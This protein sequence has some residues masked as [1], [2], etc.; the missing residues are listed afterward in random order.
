MSSVRGGLL[1]ECRTLREAEVE[2][3]DGQR[4]TEAQLHESRQEARRLREQRQRLRE[5]HACDVESERQLSAR[6]QEEVAEMETL[7]CRLSRSEQVAADH[8]EEELVLPDIR[9]QGSAA[10]PPGRPPR[11]RG[12]QTVSSIMRDLRIKDG[13]ISDLRRQLRAAS[14]PPPDSEGPRACARGIG[15]CPEVW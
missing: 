14:A 11:R 5:Q 3:A 1:D 10:W 6:L 2:A 12:S 7:R 15:S 8:Q 13:V 9:G 4:T